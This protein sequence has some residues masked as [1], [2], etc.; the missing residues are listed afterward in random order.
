M[1]PLYTPV[2]NSAYFRTYNSC[3]NIGVPANTTPYIAPLQGFFVKAVFTNPKLSFL[4]SARCHNASNYYKA[5]SSTEIL[6][7]LKTE[8]EFGADELVICK[9]PDAKQEFE[10]F[11]SEKLFSNLP[12]EM[13]S[14]SSTG[15]KL[16]INTI[17]NTDII[18]PLGIRGNTG[19]KGKITAF[20]MESSEQ[21][22]LEDRYK[23]KMIHLSENL[24]YNFEF[25]S[26]V[27]PN[28]FFIHFGDINKTLL[29]SDINVFENNNELNIVS[30]IGEE[31]QHI[32]V[33]TITGACVFKSEADNSNLF[34]ARL[35]L[36]S[37]VYLVRVKTSLGTQNV[38]INWK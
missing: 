38:K 29:N 12:V 15:E 19:N 25:Q 16:I 20:A 9:N 22:Y 36:T 4:P 28:R 5:A 8:T 11:D 23:G 35:N 30:Q 7:R 3:N 31:L 18:I 24:T 1:Y 26:D 34:T 21:V 33:Y 37:G 6:V 13:Y 32:E 2:T 27:I 17:N 14:Q 10:Q